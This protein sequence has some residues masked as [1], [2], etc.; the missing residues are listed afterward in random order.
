MAAILFHPF[1]GPNHGIFTIPP[2]IRGFPA[3]DIVDASSKDELP[4]S[5]EPHRED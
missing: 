3:T 1:E 2:G 5:G 4:S